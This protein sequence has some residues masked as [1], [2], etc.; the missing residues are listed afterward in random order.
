M[1]VDLKRRSPLSWKHPPPPP[2]LTDSNQPQIMVCGRTTTYADIFV[3]DI[4]H[5]A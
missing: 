3:F 5:T 1:L 4:R 2:M